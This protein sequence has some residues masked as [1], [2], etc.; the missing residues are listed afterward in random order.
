M[1]RSLS[2]GLLESP[3]VPWSQTLTVMELMDDLRH[4]MGVEFPA[5]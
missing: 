1:S 5:T 4:Q 3:L 2:H